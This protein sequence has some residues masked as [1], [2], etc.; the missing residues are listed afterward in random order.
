MNKTHN[1]VLTGIILNIK[2]ILTLIGLLSLNVNSQEQLHAYPSSGVKLHATDSVVKVKAEGPNV[3]FFLKNKEIFVTAFVYKDTKNPYPLLKDFAEQ[4]LHRAY[5]KF[6]FQIFRRSEVETN[7][8]NKKSVG[9]E[10]F[11][12]IKGSKCE[13]YLA[14]SVGN[15]TYIF[16]NISNE[17]ITSNC[18]SQSDKLKQVAKQVTESIAINDI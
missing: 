8:E 12:D 4:F 9:I 6:D 10:Y 7:F 2:Y 3:R 16:F 14:S 18:E 15:Q 11:I 1:K 13:L 5:A 17:I